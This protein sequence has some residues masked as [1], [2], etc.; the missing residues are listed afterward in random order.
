MYDP[1]FVKLSQ[2][3]VLVNYS[4]GYKLGEF[5]CGIPD[6]NIWIQ[7]DAESLIDSNF[8]RVKLHINKNNADVVGYIA[9]CSDSFL[10]DK[11]EKEKYGIPFS[12]YPALKIGKLAVHKN[13][14][15]KKI[16]YYLIFLTIG[17]VDAINETGVACRFITID[18]DIEFDPKTPEFYEK[19]GFVYNEHSIYQGSKRKSRG[20]RYVFKGGN[21]G[22]R[23]ISKNHLG[24]SFDE[25]PVNE[26]RI[27]LCV[28]ES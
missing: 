16:G 26:S 8:T 23:S 12:T 17:I 13:Y 18:A 11:E 1:V 25:T 28:G 10:V 4:P 5:D 27:D 14:R 20:M 22:Y 15:G 19:F 9:L 3:M 24:L 21:N 2:Q 7:N 6:Y